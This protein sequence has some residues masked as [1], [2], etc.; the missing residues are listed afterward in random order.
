[1]PVGHRQPVS[2][3]ALWQLTITTPQLTLRLPSDEQVARLADRAC[4]RVLAAGQENFLSAWAALPAGAFQDGFCA[5]H[6]DTRA[7]VTPA[8]WRLELG[9]FP[10]GETEPVGVMG[11]SGSDFTR[12]RAAVTGSWLLPD[13][14]GRRLGIGARLAMLH[15]LFDGLGARTARSGAHE[16]NRI[17]NQVSRSLGYHLDGYK[18]RDETLGGA[19]SCQWILD[20]E[21]F[22]GIRRADVRIDGLDGCLA[23]LLEP[24][25]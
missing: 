25:R 18:D 15:L 12:T 2:T 19:R 7:A 8:D 10:A 6:R 4:G 13:V 9:I 17:S 24:G 1:M 20:R 16:N 11:A 22:A 14:R 3:D 5:Y 21:R 23:L